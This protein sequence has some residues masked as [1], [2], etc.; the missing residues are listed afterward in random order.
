VIRWIS[1]RRTD[2]DDPGG[3]VVATIHAPEPDPDYERSVRIHCRFISSFDIFSFGYD[4]TQR[5]ELAVWLTCDVLW[6]RGVRDI[7]VSLVRPEFVELA[8]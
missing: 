7:V 4:D 3:L 6:H 5:I 2:D 8:C 1:G